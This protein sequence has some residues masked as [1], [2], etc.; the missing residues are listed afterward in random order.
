MGNSPRKLYAHAFGCQMSAADV[1][2]MSD[3]LAERGFALTSELSDADAVLVGTCTVRDHAEHRA[4]SYIGRLREW[5]RDHPS[6]TLI[7]AG[8]AA[9]RLGP[10]LKKRFPHVDLVAGS[11]SVADF[12]ALIGSYFSSGAAADPLRG[13]PGSATGGVCGSVT[14]MRGCDSACSYCIVPSVRGPESHRAAGE[15]LAEVRRK[16]AAGTREVTLLGQAVNRWRQGTASFADLLGLVA[17][18]PGIERV[19]FMSPHP[20]HLDETACRAMA[21]NPKVCP[22]LHLPAQSGSDRVLGLMR[23]GYTRADFLGKVAMARR[24]VPGL[25]VTTD[26]LLG[27]PSETEEDFRASL[28]LFEEM[29]AVSAFCFKYSPRAGTPSASLQDDVP[30]E[31]KEERLARLHSLAAERSAAYLDSLRGKE[32]SVLVETAGADSGRGLDGFKAR[33]D[34]PALTGTTVRAVVSGRVGNLIL[35]DI[36]RRHA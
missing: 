35:A 6:G 16:A 12:P 1:A 28:S 9:E 13:R 23:R 31:V 4:L 15:I 33:L 26:L 17:S 7:V 11:K 30:R 18:V 34:G 8:C 20:L 24:L 2:E 21:E 5:K 14:I 19:R 36:L 22:S 3:S 27:F 25:T 29:G 10:E 32:I